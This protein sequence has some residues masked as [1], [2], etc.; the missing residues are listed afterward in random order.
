M[1]FKILIVIIISFLLLSPL[2]V[3]AAEKEEEIVELST[4]SINKFYSQDSD[5]P[6]VIYEESGN[7]YLKLKYKPDHRPLYSTD[8]LDHSMCSFYFETIDAIYTDGTYKFEADLRYN[9]GLDTDNIFIS[10]FNAKK[11]SLNKKIATNIYD[12]NMLTEEIDGSEWRHLIVY[13]TID[14]FFDINYECFKFGYNTKEN[15]NNFIDMDNLSISRCSNLEF[16]EEN[17]DANN[18]GDLNLSVS[19]KYDL[20]SIGWHLNNTYY[21]D[22]CLENSIIT[23]EE[24]KVIKMYTSSTSTNVTKALKVDFAKEGMYNLSFKAKAGKDFTTNNIGFRIYDSYGIY[25][26]ETKISYKDITKD[27][28]VTINTPFYVNKDSKSEWFNL[29]LWVFTHNLDNNFSKNNY[30][31]IDDIQINK[32]NNCELTD[33]LFSKGDIVKFSR[34]L[35]RDVIDVDYELIESKYSYTKE[36]IGVE[37]LESFEVG[38]KFVENCKEQNY[39]GTL[40]YDVAAEVVNEDAKKSILLSYDGKQ[41]TKTHSSL[42]Y[43]LDF[44]EMSINKYYVLDF[45]YKLELNSN[46]L[47]EIDV[48]SVCFI[49]ADNES[50]YMIDLLNCKVGNNYTSGVNKDVFTYEIIENGDGWNHCRLIFKPNIDFKQRVTALRFLIDANFNE[51]NKFHISNISM[52]E[53]SDVE[54]VEYIPD[55]NEPKSNNKV[56]LY[57]AIGLVGLSLITVGGILIKKKVGGKKND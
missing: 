22:S 26:G 15:L 55:A 38:T 45:D 33:N 40:S 52:L 30:L 53:H 5:S 24:N 17:I 29:N 36:I 10:L 7:Q 3:S 51:D 8:N 34:N 41:K 28:W 49:G 23:E 32:A 43:L 54:Y 56:I 50:D 39:W 1:H 11:G 44:V 31:L 18:N 19:K 14:D 46:E 35:G 42:S 16:L 2:S 13:F 48:V 21:V 27:E 12:L 47:D 20:N 37:D 4:V 9:E 57:V 25:V 6:A